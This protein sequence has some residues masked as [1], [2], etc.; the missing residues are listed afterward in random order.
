[1]S[2][3]SRRQDVA[4]NVTWLCL[5]WLEARSKVGCSARQQRKLVAVPGREWKKEAF[6]ADNGMGLACFGLRV[7]LD[8]YT[9]QHFL[10][11]HLF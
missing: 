1:M 10:P 11:A 7:P 8:S 3:V 6:E 5:F 4:T 9:S 2:Q